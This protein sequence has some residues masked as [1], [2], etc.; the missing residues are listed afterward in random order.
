MH[1]YS[2]TKPNPSIHF[3]ENVQTTIKKKKKKPNLSI[4]FKQ[5]WTS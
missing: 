4:Q 5:M 2:N 1:S 3:Y